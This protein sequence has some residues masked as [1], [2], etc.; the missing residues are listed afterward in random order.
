MNPVKISSPREFTITLDKLLSQNI[1]DKFYKLIIEL[2]KQ[3]KD[4]FVFEKKSV[5]GVEAELK[6]QTDSIKKLISSLYLKMDRYSETKESPFLS[7][8]E[9]PKYDS[10]YAKESSSRILHHL[11]FN[12]T[13]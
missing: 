7:A 3:L 10:R 2:K 4:Q 12:F 5:N 13:R 1:E 11:F 8:A 6:K 9:R